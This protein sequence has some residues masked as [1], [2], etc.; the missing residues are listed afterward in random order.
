MGVQLDRRRIELKE[1]IRAA[2]E[3]VVPVKLHRDVVAE[4]KVT[5]VGDE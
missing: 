2:G 5:V 4:L 1:P 3:H